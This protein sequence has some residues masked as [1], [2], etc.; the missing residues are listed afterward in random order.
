M[1][2]YF[3]TY[4]LVVAPVVDGDN[5][6]V[7]AVTVDDVLDHIL[8]ADWRGVQLAGLDGGAVSRGRSAR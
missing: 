1:S 4:D 8:P 3:A 2:R 6:L 7:G 5:R